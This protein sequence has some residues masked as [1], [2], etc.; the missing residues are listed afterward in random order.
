MQ[1]AQNIKS[2]SCGNTNII[3]IDENGDIFCFGSNDNG[4]LGLQGEFQSKIF[5]KLNDNSLG[6]A[7]KVVCLNDATFFINTDQ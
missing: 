3:A 5:K 4:Q 2:F 6:K 7:Q 1:P